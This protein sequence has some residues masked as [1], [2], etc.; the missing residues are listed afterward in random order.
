MAKQWD[1]E[2][3]W[4]DDEQETV[5]REEQ[6]P[7]ASA[8]PTPIPFDPRQTI[9]G[10]GAVSAE[11]EPAI[12]HEN[13]TRPTPGGSRG[14]YPTSEELETYGRPTRPTMDQTALSALRQIVDE[15][16]VP[17]CVTEAMPQM[18]ADH[19][20]NVATT[21]LDAVPDLRPSQ[22]S[23]RAIPTMPPPPVHRA[24]ASVVPYALPDR[25]TTRAMAVSAPRARRNG[26]WVAV[27]V[28]VVA[29]LFAGVWFGA[30]SEGELRVD[31]ASARGTS[32]EKA[33]VYVGGD[34]RCRTVPCVVRGLEPGFETVRIEVDGRRHAV[35]QTAQIKA[36]KEE[37]LS[38]RL[39]AP[40]LR[41]LRIVE[42]PDVTD[43][44]VDGIR[45]GPPPLLLEDLEPGEHHI[46]FDGG[47][48]LESSHRTVEITEGTVVEIRDVKLEPVAPNEKPA[49][50]PGL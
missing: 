9:M 33:R 5:A 22:P 43:V 13:V 4:S 11:D 8:E 49:S 18:V 24:P 3:E 46:Q 31:V 2:L 27:A 23:R 45:R 21:R 36:G 35:L 37:T 40:K 15:G 14:G 26:S 29:G 30:P 17:A 16:Q 38:V 32:V 34:L 50:D 41:G 6:E 44:L 48:D 19:D 39:P 7:S 42:M 20:L 1:F 25:T 10:L 12:D 47:E 28:A